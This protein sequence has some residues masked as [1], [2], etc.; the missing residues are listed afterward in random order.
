MQAVIGEEQLLEAEQA[1]EEMLGMSREDFTKVP[2]LAFTLPL[3][4]QLPPP[5]TLI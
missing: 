5:W 4:L 1:A 3:T 2:L